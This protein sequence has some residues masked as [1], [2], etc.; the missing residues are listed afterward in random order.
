MS[1]ALSIIAILVKSG[2]V[3]PEILERSALLIEAAD[4]LDQSQLT[5]L[6]KTSPTFVA[7]FGHNSEDLHDRFDECYL[8]REL[9]PLTTWHCDEELEDVFWEFINVHAAVNSKTRY[10]YVLGF[11][12][13]QIVD[14]ANVFNSRGN[15]VERPR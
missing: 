13:R 2:S 3:L 15:D 6:A 4:G 14:Y 10:A 12:S 8:P 11:D 5:S 9:A 1:Q 7:F